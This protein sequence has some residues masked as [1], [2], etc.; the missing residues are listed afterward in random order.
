MIKK[1]ILKLILIIELSL[2]TALQPI[3]VQQPIPVGTLNN[4]ELYVSMY[5]T[6][7]EETVEIYF[8]IDA[9]WW[10][11]SREDRTKIIYDTISKSGGWWGD[12]APTERDLVAWLIYE[13]G[14]TLSYT[15]KVN[16]G[17]G[18]RYR[19]KYFGD[20]P[21]KFIKQLSAFTPLFNTDADTDLGMDDWNEIINPPDLSEYIEIVDYVYSLEVKKKDGAYMYWWSE[22]EVVTPRGKW[23]GPYIQ[24]QE[25]GIGTF[26]FTGIPNVRTCAMSGKNCK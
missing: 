8:P 10:I 11:L 6:T 4:K 20:T 15:D 5:E 17:K 26:Y 21:D 16:M 7:L 25:K 19:F 13:E 9:E 18:I 3:A 22:T 23:P 24:T 12:G 14:A 2:L 1:I